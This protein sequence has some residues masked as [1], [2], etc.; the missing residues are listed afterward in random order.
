MD[1]L[2]FDEFQTLAVLLRRV[3]GRLEH[4]SDSDDRAAA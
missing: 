4:V 3:R 1:D 2:T